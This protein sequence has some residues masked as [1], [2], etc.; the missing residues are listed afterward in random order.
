MQ[1]HFFQ[2]GRISYC[3]RMESFINKPLGTKQKNIAGIKEGMKQINSENTILK[4]CKAG[5]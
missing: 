1:K 5:Y 3:F 2:A 4:R